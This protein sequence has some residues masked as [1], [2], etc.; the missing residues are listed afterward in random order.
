M[1]FVSGG[2]RGMTGPRRLL[3]KNNPDFWAEKIEKNPK[4]LA[5]KAPNIMKI[6]TFSEKF[7]GFF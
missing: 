1:G 6:G 2:N 4:I 3:L 5:L 7:S